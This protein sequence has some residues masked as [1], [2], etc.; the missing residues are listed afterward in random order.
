MVVVVVVVVEWSIVSIRSCGFPSRSE[1]FSILS[2]PLRLF[3]CR[4]SREETSRRNS[5]RRCCLFLFFSLLLL[6]FFF[7]WFLFVEYFSFEPRLLQPWFLPAKWIE[8]ISLELH[9]FSFDTVKQSLPDPCSVISYFPVITDRRTKSIFSITKPRMEKLY[10][11]LS[12]LVFSCEIIPSLYHTL[13][14]YHSHPRFV[15]AFGP[16]NSSFP[17]RTEISNVIA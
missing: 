11:L 16:T 8:W 17:Q 4:S 15:L 12:I 7:I 14:V 5:P 13:Y 9:R 10:S 1:S 2:L 3:L 6:L